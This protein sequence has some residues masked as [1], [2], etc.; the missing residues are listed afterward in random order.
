MNRKLW[1]ERPVIIIGMHRSGTTMLTRLINQA[2]LY[3]GH[4]LCPNSHESYY[5][6]RINDWI[7]LNSGAAWDNPEGV[8]YLWNS[9]RS[10]ALA[11]E[12]VICHLGSIPMI[13]YFGGLRNAVRFRYGSRPIWGWKDPRTIY[14]LPLWLSIFPEAKVLYI[15]RHGVDC[16]HSLYFRENSE[17][18]QLESRVIPSPRRSFW[19]FTSFDRLSGR[20]IPS[21]RC[22]TLNGAFSLWESY[23]DEAEHHLKDIDPS[24]RLALRYEDLSLNFNGIMSDLFRFLELP[25][26]DEKLATFK[27]QLQLDR[28]YAYRRDP[29][30]LEFAES[31]K[32]ELCA[33]GY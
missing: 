27:N 24:R 3:V 19:I 15:A 17:A 16:A 7:M 18:V 13:N 28:M 9:A 20:I 5:F 32:A 33:R 8:H 14:T 29:E 12:Y 25:V 2:G 30:L 1:G 11:K 21:T 10:M 31:R 22:N 4:D 23:M 6:R 26:S